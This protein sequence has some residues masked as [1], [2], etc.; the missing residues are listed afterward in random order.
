MSTEIQKIFPEVNL[1]LAGKEFKIVP[2]KFG[3][4][5]KI[6]KLM[7]KLAVPA[8]KAIR[9]GTTHDITT[10]FGLMAEG[11]V[12][13]I[14]LMAEG[15]KVPVEFVENLDQEDGVKLLAAFIEVNKDFFVQRVLPLIQ[16]KLKTGQ[17]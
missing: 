16:S 2:F 6:M 15:I 5:P 12:E 1:E 8:Q 17:M 7:E 9:E 3:Q 11:G 4:M 14:Q 13:L 10:V